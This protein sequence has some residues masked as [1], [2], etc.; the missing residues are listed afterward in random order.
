MLSSYAPGEQDSTGALRRAKE[1]CRLLK[2]LP[3]AQK[4]PICVAIH[5]VENDNFPR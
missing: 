1:I 2:S 5:H 4:I 3:E